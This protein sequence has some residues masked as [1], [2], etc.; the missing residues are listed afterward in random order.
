MMVGT[1]THTR[2]CQVGPARGVQDDVLVLASLADPGVDKVPL[3]VLYGIAT[4]VA[5]ALSKQK[6]CSIDP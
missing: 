6:P 2:G 5:V 3:G 4:N 1:E